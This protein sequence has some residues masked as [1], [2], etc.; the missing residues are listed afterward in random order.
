MHPIPSILA[1]V[2][3]RISVPVPVITIHSDFSVYT[4]RLDKC[5][6][7]ERRLLSDASG[8]ITSGIVDQLQLP[9]TC[10]WTVSVRP[11]QHI[12]LQLLSFNLIT[13]DDWKYADER[14]VCDIL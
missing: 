5:Q 11:G 14:Q 13:L 4:S 9:V 6:T 7:S 8:Y 12:A 2:F 10:R 1:T 3:I